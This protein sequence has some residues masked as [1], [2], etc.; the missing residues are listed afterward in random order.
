MVTRAY[1]VYVETTQTANLYK[2]H[3]FV[4]TMRVLDVLL[5]FLLILPEIAH[6]LV[7][8]SVSLYFT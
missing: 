6:E 3:S 8:K 7:V 4:Q 1:L 5:P 2:Q